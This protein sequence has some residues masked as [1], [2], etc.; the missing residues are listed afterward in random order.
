MQLSTQAAT[1]LTTNPEPAPPRRRRRIAAD[2]TARSAGTLKA[3]R[4]QAAETTTRLAALEDRLAD[5]SSQEDLAELRQTL[6]REAQ[7][8]AHAAQRLTSRL[9]DAERCAQIAKAEIAWLQHELAASRNA[10]LTDPLTRVANRRGLSDWVHRI[11]EDGK[12]GLRPFSVVAFDI[13]HF[14]RVNDRHGHAAGDEVLAETA[15]RLRKSVRDGDF[16]CRLGGEEFCV[17]LPGG[18]QEDAEIVADRVLETLRG[19]PIDTGRTTI[20]VTTSAGVA[21]HQHGDTLLDTFDKADQALY[22]AKSGGRDRR[23]STPQMPAAA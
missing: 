21:L 10:S 17:L 14:K 16:V 19:R 8:L 9:G 12:G 7:A 2:L 22:A 20:R 3:E 13:D 5:A 18:S 11:L 6:E 1:S 23:C 15:R 4:R